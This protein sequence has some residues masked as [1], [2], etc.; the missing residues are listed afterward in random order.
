MAETLENVVKALKET[1]LPVTYRFFP[2]N[3]A[4]SLPYICYLTQG[5]NNFPADGQVY[6][7]VKRIQIELY[8]KHK[9]PDI[10]DKVEAVL[11][12]YFW[13]KSEEYIDSEQ[14]YQI[15][16]ELEV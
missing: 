16:Y 4:P 5:S 8:T 10:E 11:S 7:S 2:E 12:P 1:G 9:Q 13:E 6:Y 3:E 15:L 14:C